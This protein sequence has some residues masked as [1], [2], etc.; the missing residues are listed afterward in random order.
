MASIATASVA[1]SPYL[2]ALALCEQGGRRLMPLAGRSQQV[3]AAGGE[4]PEVLGH[5]LALE[6]LLRVW[7]RSDDG[8]LSRAAAS[9]SLL[10]VELPMDALPEQLPALKADWL[11][12]GDT[13]A[14][15]LALK[16][17]APRAWAM[18]VAKFQPVAL[19]PLW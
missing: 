14:C 8:A 6:L 11:T 10:L 19:T 16:G 3:V 17:I 13:D 5:A 15:L 9:S 1:D 7:Q 2:V 4:A 12:S 18:S